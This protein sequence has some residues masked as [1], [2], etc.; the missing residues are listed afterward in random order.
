[1]FS[2]WRDIIAISAGRFHS[3]GLRKDGTVISTEILD[4]KENFGQT[5]V[6]EWSNVVQISAG[7]LHTVALTQDGHI[8]YTEINK[9]A[10][11]NGQTEVAEWNLNGG[12]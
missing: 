3:I 5:E 11:D 10:D 2:G 8:L 4:K 7:W 1:M 6:A 12:D 9:K